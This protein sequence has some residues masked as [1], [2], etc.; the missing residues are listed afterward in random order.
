MKGSM[1]NLP[2]RA[3]GEAEQRDFAN[4]GV[5]TRAPGEGLVVVEIHAAPYTAATCLNK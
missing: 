3:R 5:E 2:A 1:R 4:L